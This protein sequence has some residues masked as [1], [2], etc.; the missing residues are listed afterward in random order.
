MVLQ[1]RLVQPDW[2]DRDN[3]GEGGARCRV[4]IPTRDDDGIVRNDSWFQEA[5]EALVVCNG[6]WEGGTPCPMRSQCL[7]SALVN[8]EQHGVWGGLTDPQ[9]RWIRRNISRSYWD[10]DEHLREKVP[11]PDY[12]KDYG[13][14]DPDDE[15]S[16]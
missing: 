14:E 12:F 7:L 3:E 9:R 16:R 5:E 11:P 13:D 10:D 8:N 2:T 15:A 6:D 4:H 1:S